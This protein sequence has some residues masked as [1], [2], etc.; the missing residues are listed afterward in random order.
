MKNLLFLFF[1]L[2]HI[3][4]NS[5]SYTPLLDNRNEWNLISCYLGDCFKD[6]YYTDGDT[7]VNGQNHKILDGYH[8][9][10]RTFLLRENVSE[11]KVYLTTTI[12]DIR[13]YLI[14]DFNLEEGDSINLENPITPF[15]PE[16][17]Y[18]RLDSIRINPITQ[19][20]TG[21][22]FYFSPTISNTESQGYYPIWVEG[23]GS[24]SIIN[25]PGGN[26]DYDG[27]G[28]VS[29]F[30]KNENLFYFDDEMTDQCTSTMS[31]KS[32]DFSG[33]KFTVHNS[34]GILKG[35]TSIDKIEIYDLSG[36]KH[37]SK[38]VS[39][40]D[41]L[42]F[43]LRELSKGIYVLQIHEPKKITKISFIMK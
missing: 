37:L 4:V 26:P 32:E 30:F 24:L 21:K 35:T 28:K 31:I 5:Q 39:K 3:C 19:G 22:F 27:V 9:I 11:K 1:I 23:M 14:Y 6:V 17:G 42:E 41:F 43:D 7:I 29:C 33:F 8:Y 2:F 38:F 13:E 18:F 20:E 34:K 25:A 10:S 16:G 40:K 15:P 36:K 12:D